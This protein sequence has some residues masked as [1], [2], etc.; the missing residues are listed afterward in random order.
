MYRLG[1]TL[2]TIILVIS[3]LRA[4]DSLR[5]EQMDSLTR[6]NNL[7]MTQTDSLTYRQYLDGDYRSLIGTS[8]KARRE[9]ISFYYLDYR[10]AIA[11]YALKNYAKAATFYKKTLSETP[12]DP[13]LKESLYYAY[14]LS[15]QKEN[16][17]IL[18]KTMAPHT[19][20]TVG[21][22]PSVM[23]KISLSGGYMTNDNRPGTHTI[24]GF[25][26]LNQYQNM[27]FSTLG[28][29]FKLSERT[30]FK[31]GYQ[32]YN[33]RFQRSAGTTVIME[34]NLSQHQLVAA[35]E[36]FSPSNITWGVAGGYYNI[37][38]P[39]NISIMATGQGAARGYGAPFSY[40]TSSGKRISAYSLL[41]FLNKRFTYALPEI[42]VAYSNFGETDQYQ[43]KGSLTYYPLGNLNFY[44]IS[45]AALVYT[46]NG[47]FRKQY[48][49]SQH[50][51][52][53][54]SGP[55]WLDANASLGN[56]LNYIT[57]RSFQV[58]DTYDPIKALAGLSLSW[59]LRKITM[60]A[61]YQWQQKE[62]YAFSE[63]NYTTYKYNNH[64]VNIAL[65]WN[66]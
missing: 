44:G 1:M 51:G 59:Y 56:H 46:P 7:R 13:A 19:Q 35:L 5:P 33:T 53:K 29:G 32:L 61:G 34:D 16:A 24:V 28:V 3:S 43:A 65:S 20:A 45:T 54:L 42:A 21:Y 60:N 26:S 23:D 30:K 57:E 48:I 12:D 22:T 4:Q 15:G 10:T 55:I 37:G 49:L 14:L 66:F 36:F 39:G 58:Y 52:M 47:W 38:K 25:D 63:I 27:I 8:R 11:Y 64:L 62:G 18:A 9:G 41:A 40:N 31:L 50:F 17:A 6:I 2:L